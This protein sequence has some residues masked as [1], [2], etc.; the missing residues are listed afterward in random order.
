MDGTYT[1]TVN[2]FPDEDAAEL[3]V[4]A[5]GEVAAERTVE[6]E[7]L[8]ADGRHLGAVL[9]LSFEDDDLVAVDY[10]PEEEEDRRQTLQQNFDRSPKGTD[11][12]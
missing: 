8:P 10:R 11:D 3:H 2:R 6:T 7:R 5:D 1:A 4:E 9:E 12:E